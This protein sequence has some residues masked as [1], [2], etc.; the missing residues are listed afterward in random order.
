MITNNEIEN[1]SNH[2]K[3]EKVELSINTENS[4]KIESYEEELSK[5]NSYND[6]NENF[7][8]LKK[9]IKEFY[10]NLYEINS[11]AD[12]DS[13]IENFK[14]YIED[15]Y[16]S[17][18]E[19][20]KKTNYNIEYL[21]KELEKKD[22]VLTNLQNE[23]NI[24][25]Q[26][27]KSAGS[28]SS[29]RKLGTKLESR[30]LELIEKVE[31]E[32]ENINSLNELY[33]KLQKNLTIIETKK[34]KKLFDIIYNKI[35]SY[36]KTKLDKNRSSINFTKIEN[37]SNREL[38][39]KL[40]EYNK[41]I[42][43]CNE[44]INKFIKNVDTIS[45]KYKVINSNT[46][47]IINELQSKLKV[48]SEDITTFIDNYKDRITDKVNKS[49]K[50]IKELQDEVI[51]CINNFFNKSINNINSLGKLRSN[52]TNLKNES[53]N[54]FS[55]NY[56][57]QTTS[58]LST[59]KNQNLEK[60]KEQ[61]TKILESIIGNVNIKTTENYV[62]KGSTI[63][64]SVTGNVTG[65]VNENTS[66]TTPDKINTINKLLS[67]YKNKNPITKENKAKFIL[68]YEKLNESQ[69]ERFTTLKTQNGTNAKK[70]FNKLKNK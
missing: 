32:R 61:L 34:F 25:G 33:T 7:I 14:N 68:N 62:V 59:L 49:F 30:Y 69:K 3:K 41:T 37:L 53:T 48:L 65:N 35:L 20:L 52:L 39:S 13:I 31:I 66:K 23:I 64:G 45:N 63:S 21:N 12:D 1:I 17:Y 27:Y 18:N 43:S 9:E 56:V 5:N 58:K 50:K 16:K 67:K 11:I 4:K 24:I 26:K 57:N 6:L 60:M 46:G 55:K 47:K 22:S 40:Y 36:Y 15:K 10:E 8:F 54:L 70:L 28:T 38:I 44:Y 19:Y 29:M 2:S 51:Q 42:K